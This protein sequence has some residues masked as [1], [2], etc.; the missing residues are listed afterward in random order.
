MITTKKG[1][2]TLYMNI[3]ILAKQEMA[4]LLSMR[5]AIEG[6]K[7]ALALYSSGKSAIPLRTNLTIQKYEG[8]SLY[9]P[10]Y[11]EDAHALGIKIVSVYPHNSEKKLSTVPAAIVLLNAETG[12]IKS[13][14]DGTFLTQLRTGAV[15]GAATDLLARKASSVFALIGTGGQAEKQLE[16]VLAVRPI[17]EVRIY[18]P[19][20][21]HAAEFTARMRSLFAGT[22]PAVMTAVSTPDEA[23][24]NADI[25]TA[26]TTSKTP[27]F[28]GKKVKQGA[29][30]NGIGSYM[31]DMQELPEELLQ[32]AS[33]MYLDTRE[34]VLHE[35]GDFIKPIQAGR[36]SEKRITGELGDLVLGNVPGRESAEE[37]TVFK[38]TGSA[39]LDIV[40]AEKIYACAAAQ[41]AGTVI[42]L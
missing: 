1:E 33:K 37:I 31:P 34:G 22:Y 3:T 32:R 38:S 41:R 42:T 23:I 40:I 29:H 20:Q 4:R 25:I 35:A 27:V 7:E 39:I 8:Q 26:I 11:A 12:E 16:A 21:A 14:M 2:T 15:A 10:G 30:V 9:M 13:L 19:N 18:S 5:E 6:D 36:F 24:D 17:T 28:D